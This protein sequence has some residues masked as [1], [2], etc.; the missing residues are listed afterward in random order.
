MEE[1]KEPQPGESETQVSS[2]SEEPVQ[3]PI[4]SSPQAEKAKQGTQFE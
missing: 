3:L 2:Q 4:P 1:I